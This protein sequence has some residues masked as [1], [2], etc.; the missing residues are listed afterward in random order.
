[1]KK[2]IMFIFLVVFFASCESSNSSSS[3]GSNEKYSNNQ[4]NKNGEILVDVEISQGETFNQ[5]KL[6]VVVR[7]ENTYS[8]PY[9]IKKENLDFY[10]IRK[11]EKIEDLKNNF[12][13]IIF[14]DKNE[15]ILTPNSK[16]T[17]KGTLNLKEEFFNDLGS[18]RNERELDFVLEFSQEV[19]YETI[20]SLFLKDGKVSNFVIDDDSPIYVSD[21]Q[22]GKSGEETFEY[23]ISIE[24]KYLH[25][26]MDLVEV[27][28]STKV[29]GGDIKDCLEF[30]LGKLDNYDAS[31]NGKF[32]LTRDKSKIIMS[33]DL[34]FNGGFTEGTF[35]NDINLDYTYLSSKKYVV[36]IKKEE[37]SLLQN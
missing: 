26:N 16:K 4:K 2:I 11:P 29:I 1:M 12:H 21:I 36:P 13:K 19:N 27:V 14:K 10:T 6:D 31:I 33:C 30:V 5:D 18:F 20:Q 34:S 22:T 32:D 37:I 17:F 35:Q 3:S 28:F 7:I 8:K 24:D 23:M 15:L 9:T 25:H